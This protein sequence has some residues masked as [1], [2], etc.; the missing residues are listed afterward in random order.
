MAVSAAAIE[1]STFI[2]NPNVIALSSAIAVAAAWRAWTTGA[3][4]WWVV[5]A[6]AQAVTMH[7]H[8]LGSVMLVPLAA[9]LALDARRRGSGA[10]RRRVVAAAAAGLAVVAVSYVPLLV[11]ELQSG[12]AETRAAADFLVAG[13]REGPSL[14]VRLLVVP[15]RVLSWPLAGLVTAQPVAALLAAVAVVAILA[16]R[17]RAAPRPER[18]AVRWIAV[19]FAWASLAL[20]FGASSLGSVVPG[21]PN[22]HYH[23]FLDPLVFVTVGLGAAALWRERPGGLRVANAAAIAGVGALVALN[24]AIW[25]PAVAPDGGYPAAEA[26]VRRLL[27]EAPG[28]YQLD[29]LPTLKNEN[30]YAFPLTRLG[31]GPGI[32]GDLV[33]LCDRLL[34]PIIGS[35]CGGPAEDAR[36]AELAH[37]AALVERFDASPRTVISIYR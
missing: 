14:V 26:A 33:V 20:A 23:A 15:L 10:A 19:T 16:W 31:R 3:A 24:V 12:F 7:G 5:A 27:D 6:A 36:A 13:G 25:P 2:W 30:A 8:V 32:T 21:L 11:H 35:T 1:E 4:R 18:T 17:W 37:Q 34:E 9:W 28:R 29:G 22:D